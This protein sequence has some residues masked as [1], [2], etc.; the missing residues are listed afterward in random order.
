MGN[1]PTWDTFC[2]SYTLSE[3]R[4]FFVGQVNLCLNVWGLCFILLVR[5]STSQVLYYDETLSSWG[6]PYTSF[7]CKGLSLNSYTETRTAKTRQDRDTSHPPAPISTDGRL[8]VVSW[9][10]VVQVGGVTQDLTRRPLPNTI[11]SLWNLTLHP[12]LHSF[13]QRFRSALEWVSFSVH[14]DMHVYT[15]V[16]SGWHWV[17]I[18]SQGPLLSRLI[19]VI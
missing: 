10:K 13:T 14:G 16:R 9:P 2:T 12:D 17:S 19:F 7:L 18:S 1:D 6:T 15:P 8:H 3:G 5:G 4:E 11:H